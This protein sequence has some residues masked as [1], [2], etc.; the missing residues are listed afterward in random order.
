MWLFLIL[1]CAES[2][3]HSQQ[4]HE[5]KIKENFDSYQ[6]GK[7]L[8]S[9]VN[10][11]QEGNASYS[12]DSNA[13]IRITNNQSGSI[14]MS[15]GL[16]SPT[17]YDLPLFKCTFPDCQQYATH[18]S[19]LNMNFSTKFCTRH[20][21]G[22]Q[23]E[24]FKIYNHCSFFGCRDYA[25]YRYGEPSVSFE[26]LCALHRKKGMVSIYPMCTDSGCNLTA[27]HRFFGDSIARFC[28][29]HSMSGME[30]GQSTFYTFMYFTVFLYSACVILLERTSE[31]FLPLPTCPYRLH[32]QSDTGLVI[33]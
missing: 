19:S 4:E 25:L 9:N 8:K 10:A 6:R 21:Q 33:D 26:L 28:S 24:L 1:E 30:V 32:Y 20:M 16:F 5:Q 14:D 13:Q 17:M 15:R 3:G 2:L 29:K 23:I 7:E 11:F 31:G 18:S 12:S 22:S 27:T